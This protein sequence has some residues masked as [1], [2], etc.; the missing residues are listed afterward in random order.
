MSLNRNKEVNRFQEASF[1]L[2]GWLSDQAGAVA[3]GV[4]ECI[5]SGLIVVEDTFSSPR[6]HNSCLKLY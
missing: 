6:H 2:G 3:L 4:A 5:L 1:V